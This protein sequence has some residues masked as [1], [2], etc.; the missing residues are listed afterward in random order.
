[1]L[2]ADLPTGVQISRIESPDIGPIGVGEGTFPS[3]RKTLSRLELDERLLFTEA[4]DAAHAAFASADRADKS[5]AYLPSHRDLVEAMCAQG[6]ASPSGNGLAG[7]G[8]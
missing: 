7:I 5:L 8:R 2:G 6:A 3:L 1:M 4:S